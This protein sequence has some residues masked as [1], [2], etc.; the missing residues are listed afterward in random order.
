LVEHG[1]N[2][3]AVWVDVS[4]LS[5]AVDLEIKAYL[6]SK[7]AKLPWE[8][9]VRPPPREISI[10]A[11]YRHYYGKRKV[12]DLSGTSFSGLPITIHRMRNPIWQVLGTEGMSSRPAPVPK[13]AEAYQFAEL[14]MFLPLD[15][16]LTADALND[17]QWSWPVRWLS[18]LANS[19]V[20][21]R[22]WQSGPAGFFANGEPPE[23]LGSNT[24]LSCFL[25]MAAG[26]KRGWLSR[27]DGSQVVFFT[28]FPI[29]REERDLAQRA[30]VAHLMELLRASGLELTLDVNRRNLA[31]GA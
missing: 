20:D 21:E 22:S 2:V 26:A 24:H 14:N 17:P 9:G 25:L 18:R 4:P 1:A 5:Y 23:P 7:G 31:I 16:P 6:R 10:A 3:N 15:W 8:L 27:S 13:G 12:L 19:P 11:H 28:L 29:Y 30:G